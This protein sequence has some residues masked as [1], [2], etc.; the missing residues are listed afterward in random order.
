MKFHRNTA[1]MPQIGATK[2]T[3]VFGETKLKFAVRTAVATPTF[4]K[5]PIM[6]M[7]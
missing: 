1:R 4:K 5:P 2:L 6:A 3:R 7:V